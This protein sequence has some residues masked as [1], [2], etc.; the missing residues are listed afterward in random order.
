MRGSLSRW[1]VLLGVIGAVGPGCTSFDF[2]PPTPDAGVDSG[3]FQ[4]ADECTVDITPITPVDVDV[5]TTT[6]G[7]RSN[8]SSVGGT[9]TGGGLLGADGFFAID[10]VA[11]ERWHID[12]LPVAGYESLDLALFIVRNCDTMANCRTFVNRC[13]PGGE[14]DLTIV[15]PTTERLF[16]GIDA[17]SGEGNIEF[18]ATPT[19]CGNGI[20]EEGETCDD[21]NMNN[22]DDCDTGCRQILHQPDPVEAELNN[23]AVE[24]NV[25]ELAAGAGN[26]HGTVTSECDDDHFVI[27]V[28]AGQT[29]TARLLT[30]SGAPCTGT[31]VPG[32]RLLAPNGV[33]RGTGTP[34]GMGGT[35]PSIEG[36]VLATAGEYDLFVVPPPAPGGG[37]AYPPVTYQLAV[38]VTP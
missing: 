9:C 22:T 7:L 36:L 6:I 28:A 38:S 31:V 8:L 14:E 13:G 23:W 26:V 16:V 37:M 15:F 20:P 34:G 24:A 29:V 5:E 4:L 32:L 3:L 10:V 17:V 2:P 35:C 25:I 19:H 18:L 12:T 11:G 27:S 21:G 33:E 1:S 30:T